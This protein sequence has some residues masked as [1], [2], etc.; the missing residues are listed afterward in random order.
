M[1]NMNAVV[2]LMK[3]RGCL[4]E[5]KERSERVFYDGSPECGWYI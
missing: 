1:L 3:I 2:Y 4:A 5:N